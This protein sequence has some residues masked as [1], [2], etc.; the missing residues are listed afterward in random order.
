M[1][2]MMDVAALTYFLQTEFPQVNADGP[3]FSVTDAGDGFASMRLDPSEKHLRPG[4]TVSG[5]SLFSLADVTAYMAI[6]AQ[7]GPV[8]LAVT[9]NLNINFLRKPSPGPVDAKATIL[10]L[11]KRLA[12]VEIAMTADGDLVAHA[13][14]TYSIPPRQD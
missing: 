1:A 5:P 8:A 14:A 13:T 9:T 3:V 4:G 7:I 6:L 12:V 2:A 10:K 11:G